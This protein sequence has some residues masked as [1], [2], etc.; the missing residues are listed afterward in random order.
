MSLAL[1]SCHYVLRP[2]PGLGQASVSLGA[3]RMPTNLLHH[4]PKTG[5]KKVFK[6]GCDRGTSTVLPTQLTG[7][8]GAR[9]VSLLL[10]SGVSCDP[11][12]GNGRRPQRNRHERSKMQL[13]YLTSLATVSIASRAKLLNYT[14]M[15]QHFLLK[16][17]MKALDGKKI[18]VQHFLG[19]LQLPMA[20]YMLDHYLPMLSPNEGYNETGLTM[21][22]FPSNA[23]MASARSFKTGLTMQSAGPIRE[24]WQPI[25]FEFLFKGSEFGH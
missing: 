9:F 22:F 4:G 16:E 11:P 5:P 13:K 15:V 3:P 12:K 18:M 24:P 14:T 2:R 21:H 10:Y 25:A 20:V 19:T 1:S 7:T 8:N 17:A 6:H 23:F